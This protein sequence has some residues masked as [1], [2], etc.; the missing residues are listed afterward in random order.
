FLE[1]LRHQGFAGGDKALDVLAEDDVGLAFGAAESDARGV[2]GGDQSGQA[3]AALGG[4]QVAD[5]VVVDG[6]V[7]IEDINEQAGQGLG[8]GVGNIGADVHT[9]AG[10][11][12]AGG[13][14][15]LEYVPAPLGVSLQFQR[16]LVTGNHQFAIAWKIIAQQ[17]FGPVADFRDAVAQKL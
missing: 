12:V 17:F 13:A 15:L 4:D 16:L 1:T 5:G 10:N 2:L 14:V 8:A 9:D 11:L 3:L 7:G 6:L